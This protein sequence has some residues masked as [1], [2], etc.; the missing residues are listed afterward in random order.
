MMYGMCYSVIYVIFS[1]SIAVMLCDVVLW[2]VCSEKSNVVNDVRRWSQ[3]RN[4]LNRLL[5]CMIQDCNSGICETRQVAFLLQMV[6][7][8]HKKQVDLNLT[9]TVTKK[10]PKRVCNSGICGKLTKLHFMANHKSHITKNH[11]YRMNT[12]TAPKISHM[13]HIT[14]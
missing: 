13:S 14:V 8:N 4:W 5:H 10:R 6:P 12:I 3:K 9:V 1:C 7:T 2:I 11:C